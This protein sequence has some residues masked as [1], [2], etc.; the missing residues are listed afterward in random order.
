MSFFRGFPQLDYK[1]GNED[2]T[3]KFQNLSV[4]IDLIDRLKEDAA[5]YTKYT[6]LEGDRPDVLSHKLYGNS[7]YYWTFFFLNDSLREFGWPQSTIRV[8]DW[9]KE[10]YNNTTLVSR[11]PLYGENIVIGKEV[12][13]LQSG[14]IGTI[15]KKNLSLGQIIIEGQHTF[16]D[17]ETIAVN[18]SDQTQL[19]TIT[20]SSEQYNSALYYTQN[21]EVVDIDPYVGPGALL[22]EVTYIDYYAEKNEENREIKILK[23]DAVKQIV[24]AYKK[25]LG[26]N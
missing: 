11:D 3:T 17:G 21:G 20:S 24:I 12:I 9:V 23:E 14:A 10:K 19:F 4:Y 5:F 18:D 2:Y 8:R 26:N 16:F 6:L 22:E 25:E 1:F 7:N 15:L 13:G